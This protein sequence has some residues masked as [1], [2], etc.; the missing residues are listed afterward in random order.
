MVVDDVRKAEFRVIY[1]AYYHLYC[2][3]S[4]LYLSITELISSEIVS[5][6]PLFKQ[7][8]LSYFSKD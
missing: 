5:I 6:F 2:D 4:S 8:T 7:T 1:V 3:E